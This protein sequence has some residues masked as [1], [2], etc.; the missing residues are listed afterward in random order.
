M[1]DASRSDFWRAAIPA[2]PLFGAAVPF[3]GTLLLGGFDDLQLVG[4]EVSALGAFGILATMCFP[5]AAYLAAVRKYNEAMN[6]RAR[7]W[8]TA[9]GVIQ[10]SAV[11]RKLTG[12]TTA[13][14]VLD[15]EYAYTVGERTYV[16]KT[17][18]FAPRYVANKDL[19]F[20]LFEK[21]PTQ[22]VVSVHYD[23][24]S[25]DAAV[26]ETS[27]ELARGDN[28][29]IWPLVILPFLAALFMAVRHV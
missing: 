28:W 3:I 27:G 22:A 25:P 20:R 24:A 12:W 8:P 14:W 13:L 15:V 10:S 19:I 9:S 16:S 2:A 26:L 17:L 5:I 6:V 21:Y 29:R 18:G 1:T 7:S 23:T 11:G 4:Q